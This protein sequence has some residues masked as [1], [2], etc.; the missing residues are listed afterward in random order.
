MGWRRVEN[1]SRKGG[2]S[3]GGAW[4]EVFLLADARVPHPFPHF[5][6]HSWIVLE[7]CESSVQRN[8]F[9]TE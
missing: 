2:Q 7:V 8:L 4:G 9:K 6:R 5:V 1:P 3:K